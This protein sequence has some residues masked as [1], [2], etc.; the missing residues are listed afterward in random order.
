MVVKADSKPAV[1]KGVRVRIPFPAICRDG[2]M[3]Y[4]RVL[5]TLARMGLGVQIPLPAKGV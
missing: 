4:T 2:G 3:E 1:Q 5:K